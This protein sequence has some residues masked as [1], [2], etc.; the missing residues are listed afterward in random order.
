MEQTSKKKTSKLYSSIA[1]CPAAYACM[2]ERGQCIENAREGEFCERA[3]RLAMEHR[4]DYQSEAAA[5][6]AIAGKLGCSPD[7]L[8]IWMR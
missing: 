8:R 3:V 4:K 5:P 2:R 7:G 1:R 6:T